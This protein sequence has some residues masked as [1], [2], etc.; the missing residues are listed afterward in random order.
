M[1]K[2]KLTKRFVDACKYT[3]KGQTIYTDSELPGFG[4]I[5]G[6]KTKTYFAQKEVNGRTVRHK[7]GTHGVFNPEQARN[8][9]REKLI[10]MSRGENL[11]QTKREAAI[12]GI[13][14]EQAIDAY[15]KS[16][17]RI[18]CSTT[19][20]FK[21]CREAWLTSWLKLSMVTITK[22][23]VVSRHKAL[24]E[25]YGGATANQAMYML[26]AVYNYALVLYDI[27]NPNPVMVLSQAKK[28]H[29]QERRTRII[30]STQ[31]KHWYET[32]MLLENSAVR[33]YLCLLLFTGMRRNE[34]LSLR[35]E[36]VDFEEKIFTVPNTKNKKPLLLPMSN[37]IY[38][39]LQDRKKRSGNSEWVFPSNSGAGH[40]VEP[41]RAVASVIEK[42]GVAFTVH[43]L[44][45]T[46]ITIAEGLDIQYYALKRLLN[47]SQKGDVTAG[48]IIPSVDRLRKPMQQI[49]DYILAM[50]SEPVPQDLLPL[51]A[52]PN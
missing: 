6:R 42:S 38:D 25:E 35:W 1:T 49:T 33:H 11:N 31:L 12:K 4:L 8:D 16:R 3:Q 26:R 20:K 24:T 51:R 47:H 46:F 50:V 45:R 9:A 39:V 23:M 19:Y 32:V 7:I 22:E 36:N 40:L 28:W 5:V 48:Y 17:N 2:E 15:E 21:R 18:S 41:K 52:L 29:A 37:Y 30:K 43:D 27:T 34:A 10:R 44:R 14:L 13:T